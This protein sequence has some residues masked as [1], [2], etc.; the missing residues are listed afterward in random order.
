MKPARLHR[1]FKE[2][3]Y[4]NNGTVDKHEFLAWVDEPTDDESCFAARCFSLN[5][6]DRSH[7]MDF[8]EFIGVVYNYCSL[9]H[10]KLCKFAFRLVDRDNSGHLTM[11]ELEVLVHL[12]YGTH[13]S[14]SDTGI[15]N[16]KNMTNV[17][18]AL[19]VL[20]NLDRDK[21][22]DI[23]FMEFAQC[24]RAHPMLLFPAFQV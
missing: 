6:H 19:T 5:D 16:S 23:S 15:Y 8:M 13:L 2:C 1:T 12:V 9:D 3:D 10:E 22:G 7:T 20:K 11:D 18:N 21:S 17:K 14:K 4:D 24:S